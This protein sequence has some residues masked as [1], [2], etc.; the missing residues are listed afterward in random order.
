MA[1]ASFDPR[2]KRKSNCFKHECHPQMSPRLCF[3]ILE[4]VRLKNEVKMT[5]I[6]VMKFKRKLL[7][8]PI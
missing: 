6:G 5:R 8:R 2:D 1:V 7:G 3:V 4:K